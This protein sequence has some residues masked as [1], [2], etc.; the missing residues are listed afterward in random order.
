M[1]KIIHTFLLTGDTIIPELHLNQPGLTY[2]ACGLFT[3]YHERIKKF[4]ETDD[5]KHLYGNELDKACF[6][7]DPSCSDSKDLAKR[8][9][10]YKIL[11]DKAHEIVRDCGYDGYQWA[12]A[13]EVDKFFDTKTGSRVSV[14][15]QL[16][17][18]L[19]KPVTK[20]FKRKKVYSRFKD[21]IW[22]VYLIWN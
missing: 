10:S 17:R 16:V 2:S 18:E 3:K 7:H 14:N 22:A 12:L 13:S 8:T 6:A 9:I 19:H 11:K 21:N 20:N 15:K 5:L 1:N 4:S